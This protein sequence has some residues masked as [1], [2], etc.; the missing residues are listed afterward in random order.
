MK[1]RLRDALNLFAGALLLG[2]IL[3]SA[4]AVFSLL[5]LRVGG[6]LS[7]KQAHAYELL[8]DILP[9]PLYLVEAMLSVHHGVE[10]LGQAKVTLDTLA[11]LKAQDE[12]RRDYWQTVGLP[13]EILATLEQSQAEADAFWSVV[14]QKYAPA[15][16][17][18]DIIAA[19]R[20]ISEL[21][22]IYVRHRKIID[23][24]AIMANKAAADSVL[25]AE[26]TTKIAFA[27]LAATTLMMLV[28][29]VA[30]S[31]A[32]RNFV[33]I[34]LSKVSAY[35][36]QL[37]A[38]DFSQEVPMQ[39]RAD[40]VGEMARS[41]ANFRTASLERQAAKQAE[42]LKQFQDQDWAAEMARTEERN[43]RQQVVKLLGGGLQQLAEGNLTQRI[44]AKF[45]REFECLRDDFNSSLEI[46]EETMGRVLDSTSAVDSGSREISSASDDLARRTEQQAASLEETAAA[47][48]QVTATVR[49]TAENAA[50]AQKATSVSRTMVGKSSAVANEAMT[51]MERIDASSRQIGQIITVIDE[52]AFQ[53]NLLALNAGV[54]AARAGEAGRGF[55]VVAQEVRAL[56]QRSADAAKEIKTLVTESSDSVQSG[57]GL[58]VRVG[59]ELSGVV[60]HFGRI[61]DLV[62]T[63]ASAARHQAVGLAEIN[64][65]VGQMDQV[66]QQNAAMVEQTTAASHNLTREASELGALIQRFTVSDSAT[67]DRAA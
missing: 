7:K 31:N 11:T 46:L 43:L 63:I 26:R 1:L 40:E 3:A 12:Q 5:E 67:H 60:D 29:V 22:P 56:A 65:A 18:G 25:E 58:V 37:A 24:L 42:Q 36:G 49:Q 62:N 41:V 17:S 45:P 52:I 27:L 59:E 4:T 21:E 50:E 64:N 55:A 8:A 28:L 19:N 66:T 23:G 57:V 33:V 48:D 53:T 32:L 6:P 9:P 14:D 16:K 13:K 38:G 20:S 10:D 34:P 30:G 35:M 47:L 54:E 44:T 61:E 39:G 51:A 2:F 15:L